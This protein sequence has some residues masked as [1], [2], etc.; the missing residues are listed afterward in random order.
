MNTASRME[1]TSVK[2]HIHCSERS[3][4]IL[5]E[6]VKEKKIQKNVNQFFFVKGPGLGASHQ[7][8]PGEG[9]V[10]KKRIVYIQTYLCT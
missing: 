7:S 5:M 9:E 1:S 10:V 3:A 6:Q 2:G 8:S 4:K